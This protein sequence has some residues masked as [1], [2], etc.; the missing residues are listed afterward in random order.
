MFV[1]QPNNAPAIIVTLGL[2]DSLWI[3]EYILFMITLLIMKYML[4]C[5]T[6][7]N[8]KAHSQTTSDREEINNL[9]G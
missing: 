9:Y 3:C 4:E 5:F 6:R 2:V 7:Y 1:K 8:L